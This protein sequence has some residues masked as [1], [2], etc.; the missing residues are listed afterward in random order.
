MIPPTNIVKTP[1]L[2]LDV[3]DPEL[4]PM[5]PWPSIDNACMNA[6]DRL[7]A[8]TPEMLHMRYNHIKSEG[9]PLGLIAFA[10]A[11]R[12]STKAII[13]DDFFD[14]A[15]ARL[16]GAWLK[17]GQ[18]LAELKI[19]TKLPKHTQKMATILRA[20]LSDLKTTK[21]S[22]DV[23]ALLHSNFYK[24]LH[25]RFAVLDGELWHFGASVGGN[26]PALNACSRGWSD[27]EVGFSDL[28]EKI[29]EECS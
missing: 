24:R 22:V 20:S 23:R 12:S 13:L 27:Q 6:C 9:P 8:P 18:R 21:P 16:V 17:D 4:T 5:M 11:L 15:S 25:D 28:F 3:A 2:I 10:L 19:L 14:L 1:K 29:W 7:R 26:H